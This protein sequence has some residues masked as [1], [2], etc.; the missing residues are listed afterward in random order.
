MKEFSPENNKASIE[1][2]LFNRPPFVSILFNV[3][4]FKENFYFS[5]T[6][7]TVLQSVHLSIPAPTGKSPT[8]RYRPRPTVNIVFKRLAGI[9]GGFQLPGWMMPGFY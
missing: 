5:T 9:T 6:C 4:M 8:S 1:Y 2:P 7:Y 3:N